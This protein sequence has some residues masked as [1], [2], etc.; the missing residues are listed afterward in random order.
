[1]LR[2]ERPTRP[3]NPCEAFD[4]FIISRLEWRSSRDW[5]LGSSRLRPLDVTSGTGPWCCIG[6]PACWWGVFGKHRPVPLGFALV[7]LRGKLWER[8]SLSPTPIPGAA[9]ATTAALF[10]AAAARKRGLRWTAALEPALRTSGKV[11]PRPLTTFSITIIVP[12]GWFGVL[13]KRKQDWG[14]Y[15]ISGKK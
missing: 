13:K 2:L 7:G 12:G 1:M 9:A 6:M 10:E 3:P 15:T 11:R 14:Y 8:R 4:V 5:G